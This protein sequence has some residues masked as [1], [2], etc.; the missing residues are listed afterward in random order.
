[1]LEYDFC[2]KLYVPCAKGYLQ[3]TQ[4][5]NGRTGTSILCSHHLELQRF[6]APISELYTWGALLPHVPESYEDCKSVRCRHST[7]VSSINERGVHEMK[8]LYLQIRSK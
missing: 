8:A 1:M 4:R 2:D 3:V 6:V 7:Y 5:P